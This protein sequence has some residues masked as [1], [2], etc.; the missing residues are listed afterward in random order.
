V[1]ASFLGLKITVQT[2]DAALLATDLPRAGYHRAQ[3]E[4]WVSECLNRV[5][6]FTIKGVCVGSEQFPERPA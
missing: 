1:I 4:R 5:I 3:F 6:R 2:K